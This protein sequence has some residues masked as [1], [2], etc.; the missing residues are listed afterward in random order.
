MVLDEYL[1]GRVDGYVRQFCGDEHANK[2]RCDGCEPDWEAGEV[3]GGSMNESARTSVGQGVGARAE[4]ADEERSLSDCMEWEEAPAEGLPMESSTAS[5]SEVFNVWLFM[6]QNQ[7]WWQ[8][9]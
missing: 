5:P 7:Q 6:E 2:Q 4:S 3:D 1:D 9:H 8:L